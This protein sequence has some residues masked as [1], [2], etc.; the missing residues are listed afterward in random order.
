MFC[1][2]SSLATMPSLQTAPPQDHL[3]H[4]FQYLTASFVGDRHGGAGTKQRHRPARR[5]QLP[6][7][8]DPG[9][10]FGGIPRLAGIAGSKYAPCFLAAE[11]SDQEAICNGM[12]LPATYRALTPSLDCNYCSRQLK[13]IESNSSQCRSMRA[14][15]L[16][17]PVVV[18]TSPLSNHPIAEKLPIHRGDSKWCCC[19]GG[20]PS[21]LPPKHPPCLFQL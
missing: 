3:P 20:T 2:G 12:A 9:P 7:R 10:V 1:T 14:D 17:V 11:P 16:Y 21:G 19:F 6:V 8:R 18:T 4:P 5:C 13:V 15:G